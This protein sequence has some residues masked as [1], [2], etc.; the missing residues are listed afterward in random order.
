MAGQPHTQPPIGKS[1]HSDKRAAH[2]QITGSINKKSRK[3]VRRLHLRSSRQL[4][5]AYTD[6]HPSIP[7][8]TKEAHTCLLSAAEVRTEATFEEAFGQEQDQSRHRQRRQNY[9]PKFHQQAYNR[10]EH[11]T[12]E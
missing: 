2:H 11:S 7:K 9:D 12:C 5:N 8:E 3:K 1:A 10:S 4:A 6:R